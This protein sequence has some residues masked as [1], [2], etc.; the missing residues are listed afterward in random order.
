MIIKNY[1]Q[2]VI[3]VAEVKIKQPHANDFAMIDCVVIKQVTL[4]VP[5]SVR[6]LKDCG[7]A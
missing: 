5:L 7:V 6:H 1:A 3:L 4:V 2:I